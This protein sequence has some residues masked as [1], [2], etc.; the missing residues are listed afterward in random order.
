MAPSGSGELQVDEERCEDDETALRTSSHAV[1]LARQESERLALRRRIEKIKSSIPKK[2]RIRRQRAKEDAAE[3]ER[4]LLDAQAAER[5]ECGVPESALEARERNEVE[6]GAAA[7]EVLVAGQ[8]G[9]SKAARRRRRKAEQEA[10]AQRRVEEE[11]AAMGPSPK[12]VEKAA[13]D[14]QLNLKDLRIHAI[15]ADGHCLYSAIAHQMTTT[16]LETTVPPTVD[17]LR[18]ATADYLLAN[19]ST[20]MPFVETVNCDED[21]F[22]KYCEELRNEVVWGGQVELRAMAELLG[23]EIEVYA[24]DMPIV[25]MGPTSASTPALRVSFHR[26]YLGLGEHYNS[27]VP[28]AK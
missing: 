3:E 16:N 14:A 28:N 11:K 5:L 26:Q 17:G 23:T 18:A 6:L 22:R 21:L 4:R 12:F 10:E 1:I 2:D 9:E 19:M 13:I 20:F 7:G 24:A 27:V 8:R 25:R 15:A